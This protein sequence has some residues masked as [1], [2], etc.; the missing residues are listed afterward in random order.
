[1]T[2]WAKQNPLPAFFL[3]TLALGLLSLS[4]AAWTVSVFWGLI[5][6]GVVLLAGGH[7][8]TYLKTMGGTR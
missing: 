6:T 4:L 7:W 2:R 1:M 3:V 8:V 5:V